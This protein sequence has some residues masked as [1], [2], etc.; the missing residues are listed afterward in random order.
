MHALGR[1]GDMPHEHTYADVVGE[2]ASSLADSVQAARAAGIRSILVDPGFG[3]GKTTTENLRLVAYTERIA[4]ATGCPVLVGASRKST[5]GQV[6]HPG[7]PPPA[8]ER[9]FGSVGM[10][11][12]AVRWG[13]SVV[14]VHDVRET[15]EALRVFAA[16]EAERMG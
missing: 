10:A 11:V 14:R 15:V 2:V 5:I 12:A 4:S 6:L 7:D 3:F 8:S 9:V 13:A 16:V 1:P